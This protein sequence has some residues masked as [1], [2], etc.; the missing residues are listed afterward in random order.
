MEKDTALERR[1]QPVTVNEPSIDDSIKIMEGIAH[2]YEDFHE[3]EIPKE[4]CRAA[5]IMSERYITD[6]FL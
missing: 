2:Y 1:F 6:R 5:V 3:V 4:M